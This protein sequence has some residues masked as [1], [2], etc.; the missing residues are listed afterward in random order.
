MIESANRQWASGWPILALAAA[1][2]AGLYARTLGFGFIDD[3]F[4]LVT[5]G[6]KDILDAD[7]LAQ[8]FWP[9]WYL[10]YVVVSEVSGASSVAHHLASH[11][12]HFANCALALILMRRWL[13]APQAAA[14]VLI[15]TFLPQNA[16]AYTWISQR[17]DLLM[18]LCLL[19]GLILADRGVRVAG[20]GGYVL[21]YMSKGTCLFLPLAYLTERGLRRSRSDPVVA[22]LLIAAA[23]PFAAMAMAAYGTD[24]HHADLGLALRLANGAK[25]I[26]AGW[27]VWFV[28]IPFLG[29]A[30]AIGGYLA[31]ALG[32][33]WLLWRHRRLT[34]ATIRLA[35]TAI[36]I[37]LT[38]AS[39]PEIRITYLLGLFVVAAL[40]AAIDWQQALRTKAGR[41]A[42]LGA[43]CGFLVYALPAAWHIT[44]KFESPVFDAWQP[45]HDGKD[46]YD[47]PI[48][49][50]YPVDFYTWFREFQIDMLDRLRA[51]N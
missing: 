44:G 43:T 48:G 11:L 16:F 2:Y 40:I 37:S 29:S 8:Y 23:L 13:T 45:V 47:D 18:T 21:A 20:F 12:L 10:S 19:G 17:N 7:R 5:M 36:A 22:I 41:G 34:P 32:A 28:P 49:N 6:W 24:V 51:T 9:V 14:I 30:S 35:I 38:M 39:K 42:I 1:L 15:W 46:Y 33:G 3:D 50:P 27:V 4:D 31:F 26:V 25:N